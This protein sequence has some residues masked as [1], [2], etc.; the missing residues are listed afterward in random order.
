MTFPIEQLSLVLS[1]S[2][3]ITTR[4]RFGNKNV[5]DVQDQITVYL[6]SP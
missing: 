2:K 3:G 6:Y 1:A 4:D 5:A